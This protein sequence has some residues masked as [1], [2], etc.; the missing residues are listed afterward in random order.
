MARVT[1]HRFALG[2]LNRQSL[3]FRRKSGKGGYKGARWDT[4]DEVRTLISGLAIDID[5]KSAIFFPSGTFVARTVER[6][7][8]P[9]SFVRRVPGDI[10]MAEINVSR[11]SVW[12]LRFCAMVGDGI[13]DAP[14]MKRSRHRMENSDVPHIRGEG[15]GSGFDPAQRP[16]FQPVS[17]KTDYGGDSD[18]FRAA[19]TPAA[20]DSLDSLFGRLKKD[21]IPEFRPFHHLI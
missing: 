9:R 2:L 13:N 5:G 17:T 4:T 7:I 3:L 19:E 8:P 11:D 16:R 21:F 12:Q 18:S 14:T 15:C 1:R 20:R 6:I 10:G